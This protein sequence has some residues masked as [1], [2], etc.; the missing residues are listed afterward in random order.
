MNRGKLDLAA[1]LADTVLDSKETDAVIELAFAMAH[2]NGDASPDELVA[3]RSLIK[4]LRPTANVGELFEHYSD[5]FAGPS[6]TTERV[7]VAATNLTRIAARELA[8]KAVYAVAIYDL[9]T[10][11]EEIELETLL[12]EALRIGEARVREL[13]QETTRAL[14]V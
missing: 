12:V 4:Y 13:G 10:N 6:S 9:E 11:E 1:L 3:L 7:R 2:A 14:L 8:Y 5:V